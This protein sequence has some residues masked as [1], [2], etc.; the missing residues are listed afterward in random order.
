MKQIFA[1]LAYLKGLG[2]VHRQINPADIFFSTNTSEVLKL[3]S[4]NRCR[5]IGPG[6]KLTESEGDLRLMAPEM[7]RGSYDYSCDMWSAGVLMYFL[8]SSEFP[9]CHT[10]KGR[11]E[12]KVRSAEYSFSSKIWERISDEAKDLIERILVI[13]TDLRI[14]PEEAMN[15]PWFH[16]LDIWILILMGY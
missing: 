8:L 15:H 6:E 3:I 4:F 7:I 14:S 12:E 10:L 1:M 2:I 9:F 5:I 11:L 16:Y 13:D